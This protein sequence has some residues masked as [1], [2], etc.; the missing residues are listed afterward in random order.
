MTG[1][2]FGFSLR[3]SHQ[4]L[5]WHLL[6]CKGLQGNLWI[7][8]KLSLSPALWMEK[9]QMLPETE[10]LACSRPPICILI[11]GA[12]C[13][14]PGRDQ[15]ASLLLGGLNPLV[16]VL[17]QSWRRLQKAT[18]CQS[19]SGYSNNFCFFLRRDHGQ[20][21]LLWHIWACL[22]QGDFYRDTLTFSSKYN[23]WLSMPLRNIF[24]MCNTPNIPAIVKRILCHFVAVGFRATPF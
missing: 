11:P 4:L 20:V 7:D 19:T 1:L 12:P 23:I 22:P 8:D 6:G 13:H 24:H 10:P 16:I 17:V 2:C 9:S 18:T 5:K 15:I 3:L 14:P 21:M